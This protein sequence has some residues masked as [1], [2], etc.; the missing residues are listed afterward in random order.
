MTEQQI[1]PHCDRKITDVD[2]ANYPRKLREKE[3]RE[4]F[5]KSDTHRKSN[6]NFLVFLVLGILGVVSPVILISMNIDKEVSETFYRNS[7][8]F[9]VTFFVLTMFWVVFWPIRERKLCDK[10][11]SSKLSQLN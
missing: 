11:V 5:L 3:L 2:L 10:Y 4:E 6:K 9:Q 7:L 1:C 8:I